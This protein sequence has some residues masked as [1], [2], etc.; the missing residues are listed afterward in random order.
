MKLPLL[1]IKTQA[2][3][4]FINLLFPWKTSLSF[5]LSISIASLNSVAHGTEGPKRKPR[6]AGATGG[7]SEE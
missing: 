6:Q 7:Q 5:S 4:D 1:A 3:K 2:I